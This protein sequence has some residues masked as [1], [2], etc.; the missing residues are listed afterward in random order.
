CAR[1]RACARPPTVCSSCLHHLSGSIRRSTRY[2]VTNTA[3]SADIWL[4]HLNELPPLVEHVDGL[5]PVKH[6][7]TRSTSDHDPRAALWTRPRFRYMKTA[8]EYGSGRQSGLGHSIAFTAAS[9]GAV[10]R[11]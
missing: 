9:C 11:E 3:N 10:T 8:T 2:Q 6:A 1:F 4:Q 7:V 5:T